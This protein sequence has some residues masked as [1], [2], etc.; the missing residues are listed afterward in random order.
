MGKKD[1]FIVDGAKIKCSMGD[2]STTLKV[3]SQGTYKIKGKKAATMMDFIPGSNL[4]PP[5]ATFGTC[6]PFKASPPP[7]QLCTPIPTGPWMNSFQEMK[8]KG[9]AILKGNACLMCGRAGGKISFEN[10]GQ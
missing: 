9:K 10:S 8:L 3:T 5:I 1:E 6:K 2:K 4:F 7:A